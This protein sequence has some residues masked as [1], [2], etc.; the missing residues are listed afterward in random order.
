M[1]TTDRSQ[2][3][4]PTSLPILID[5]FR[6]EMAEELGNFFTSVCKSFRVSAGTVLIGLYSPTYFHRE[7]VNGVFAGV[8]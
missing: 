5:S 2:T 3:L 4:Q 8:I 7:I 6:I 1:S